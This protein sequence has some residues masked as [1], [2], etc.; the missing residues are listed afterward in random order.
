MLLI[1][2]YFVAVAASSNGAMIYDPFL[3]LT[4]RY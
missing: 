1:C 3:P 2:E 4:R